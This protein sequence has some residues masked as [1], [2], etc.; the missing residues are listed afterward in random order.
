MTCPSLEE[1][2]QFVRG[3][4][5]GGGR[6][7]IEAHL[8]AGCG[9]CA[10]NRRWLD[11]LLTVTARDDSFEFS[12]ETIQWSVAQFKAA[13]G[14]A[15]SRA[16]LLA[17]LVFDN[18]IPAAAGLRSATAA[19]G[20]RQMLFQAGGYEVDLRIEP[21]EGSAAVLIIGQ[22]VSAGRPVSELAGLP[23][24]VVPVGT[25]AGPR[26][27]EEKRTETDAR[28]MFRLRGVP[29]GDYDMIID[30]SEGEFSIHA[31]TCRPE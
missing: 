17:R 25:P 24:R 3:S 27:G 13:A 26:T 5:Q 1:L 2:P 18:L 22:I 28:G 15:P 6:A 23:V 11:D 7:N 29:A 4:L 20:S 8:A 14:M 31:I 9:Q 10:A 21:Q 19:A 30:V 16:Q 12:E